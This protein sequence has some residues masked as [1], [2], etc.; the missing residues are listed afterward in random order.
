M[1]TEGPFP[2]CTFKMTTPT[3]VLSPAEPQYLF[4]SP[5]TPKTPSA[6][7]SCAHQRNSLPRPL[8]VAQYY[9]EAEEKIRNATNALVYHILWRSI[10]P[11][12]TLKVAAASTSSKILPSLHSAVRHCGASC[13]T[14]WSVID[15]NSTAVTQCLTR[16]MGTF[17]FLAFPP[18]FRSFLA[19]GS[20]SGRKAWEK[21]CATAPCESTLVR[22]G[23]LLAAMSRQ[24]LH[25]IWPP[26][27]S[28]Q[29][30]HVI[31]ALP[32][33]RGSFSPVFRVRL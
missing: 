17:D 23:H 15:S 7:R 8:W 12:S 11:K 18:T 16:Q 1:K 25:Y 24:I 20:S 4:P 22:P 28:C 3:L 32:P 13:T 19:R 14:G 30:C 31:L 2:A 27:A 9:L 6:R 5:K 33:V 10:T 29:A 26:I 21:L